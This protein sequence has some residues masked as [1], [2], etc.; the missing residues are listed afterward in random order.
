[1]FQQFYAAHKRL[2]RAA[3]AVLAAAL[4]AVY[5]RALLLPGL[6][7]QD[8]FLR[9]QADGSFS[10]SSLGTACSAR[11]TPEA[12]GANVRVTIDNE[13]RD[14]R[15]T[16]DTASGRVEVYENG[17][18]SSAGTL[19]G[20]EGEAVTYLPDDLEDAVQVTVVT[21]DNPA[22][23]ALSFPDAAWLA[24]AAFSAKCD[25]RGQPVL[26][27][28]IALFAVGL[29]LDLVWPD[30]FWQLRHGLA[31]NGGEPSHF[32]RVDQ[33]VGRGVAVVGILVLVWLSFAM[34]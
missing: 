27:L 18:L 6:W 22:A 5:L 30:L 3:G 16:R 14:Y 28:P 13:T 9:R 7:Y 1:M 23:E 29:V 21:T 12:D 25:T 17:V 4:L 2:C 8:V 33:T 24:R 34:H 15:L 20:G 31:V 10:G 19:Y 26:L 11:I 32:Y